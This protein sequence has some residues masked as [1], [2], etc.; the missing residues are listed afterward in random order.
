MTKLWNDES[1]NAASKLSEFR[2]QQYGKPSAV[3]TKQKQINA[4]KE[5]GRCN[6]ILGIFKLYW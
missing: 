3:L 2:T 5:K 6:H 4:H 1:E